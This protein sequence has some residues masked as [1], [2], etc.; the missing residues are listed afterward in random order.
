MCGLA[1][2]LSKEYSSEQLSIRIGEMTKLLEHRGP[3]ATNTLVKD[4]IAL[5]H[6]RLSIIDLTESGNQPMTDIDSGVSIVL[7]GEIY[8]FKTLKAELLSLGVTFV[9][10]SDTEVLLRSY[11]YWGFEGLKKIEGIF[12]CGVP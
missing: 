10:T 8:N 3:D 9:G 2:I 4:N 1:G 11:I 6:T 5:G 7:N 12:F